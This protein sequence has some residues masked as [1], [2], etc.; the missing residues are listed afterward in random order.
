MIKNEK[1]NWD[2][3][4]NHIVGKTLNKFPFLTEDPI[5]SAADEG[6]WLAF[7]KFDAN[8]CKTEK[9]KYVLLKGYFMTIDILRKEGFL[10]RSKNAPK[11]YNMVDDEDFLINSFPCTHKSF[12]KIWFELTDG[13]SDFEQNIIHMRYVERLTLKEMQGVLRSHNT[14]IAQYI[15]NARKKICKLQKVSDKNITMGGQ[16]LGS[17]RN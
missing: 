2:D 8:K 10:L 3:V 4:I 5:R 12:S 9:I 7:L 1:I 17:F 13:L 15:Y 11:T 14:V 6:S 16:R